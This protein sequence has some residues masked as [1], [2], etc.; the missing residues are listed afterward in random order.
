MPMGRMKE[1]YALRE[2]A[3]PV[4]FRLLVETKYELH[5]A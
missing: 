4:A 1:L 2:E 3:H 5:Q